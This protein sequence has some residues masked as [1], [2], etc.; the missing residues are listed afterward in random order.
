MA[1][2]AVEVQEVPSAAATLSSS[3]DSCPPSSQN[4]TRGGAANQEGISHQP[5]NN[6]DAEHSDTPS[7][8]LSSDLP[9][10][11]SVDRTEAAVATVAAEPDSGL[12]FCEC[13][14]RWPP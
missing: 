2:V 1:T 12:D 7:K 5:V 10:T 8:S 11:S 9:G 3:A 6:V 13:A 14:E 4:E